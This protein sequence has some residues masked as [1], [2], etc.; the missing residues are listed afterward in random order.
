MTARVDLHEAHAALDHAAGHE[1]AF[2]KV[3]GV[4]VADAVHGL[5]GVSFAGEVED[6]GSLELHAGGHLVVGDA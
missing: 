3:V 2:G 1:A 4:L 6:V 5:G